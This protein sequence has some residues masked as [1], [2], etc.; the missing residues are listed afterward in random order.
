[1][2]THVKQR[3]PLVTKRGNGIAQQSNAKEDQVNLVGL[4]SKN[5]DTRLGLEHIDAPDKEEGSTEVDGQGNGDVTDNV[6]PTADP[7]SDTAP[8]TRSQHKSLV[9]HT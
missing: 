6:E 2:V 1:M 3:Q 5:T 7:T 8:F 4:A 9:V